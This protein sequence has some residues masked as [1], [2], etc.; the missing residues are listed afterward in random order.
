MWPVRARARSSSRT[1]RSRGRTLAQGPV[2]NLGG[3]HLVN[4]LLFGELLGTVDQVVKH[5]GV[6]V[7][8]RE[9]VAADTRELVTSGAA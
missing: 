4:F 1:R 9:T 2:G 6:G 5:L 8:L 7:A 3:L